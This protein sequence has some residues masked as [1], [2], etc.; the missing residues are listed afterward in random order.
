MDNSNNQYDIIRR[1]RREGDATLHLVRD[2]AADTFRVLKRYEPDIPEYAEPAYTNGLNRFMTE[3][4]KYIAAQPAG[5]AIVPAEFRRDGKTVV[6]ASAPFTGTP[7]RAYW[8]SADTAG[9]SPADKLRMVLPILQTVAA[10]NKTGMQFQAIDTDSVYVAQ[11]AVVLAEFG[12]METFEPWRQAY[13]LGRLLHSLGFDAATLPPAL[14]G[15]L[16]RALFT[17]PATRYPDAESFARDVAAFYTV[18]QTPLP[19]STPYAQP[20]PFA[21]PRSQNKGCLTAAIAVIAVLVVLSVVTFFAMRAGV[22]NNSS[23]TAYSPIPTITWDIMDNIDESIFDNPIFSSAWP[24]ATGEPADSD[25]DD[26]DYSDEDYED[27]RGVMDTAYVWYD[28]WDSY[29][30]YDGLAVAYDGTT[31]YRVRD[32]GDVVLTSENRAGTQTDLL[33]NYIPAF[34]CADKD[35]LY[36]VD[37]LD[38]YTL[39]RMERG[40]GE[41]ECIYASPCAFLTLDAAGNCIYFSD[42][43]R[44]GRLTRLSLDTLETETM[45][46][47]EANC[48]TLDAANRMLYYLDADDDDLIY[49]YNILTDTAEPLGL[50]GFDLQVHDGFLYYMG[51][52]GFLYRYNTASGKSER[53]VRDGVYAYVAH[54][55][56]VY[57]VDERKGYN[58]YRQTIGGGSA[59]FLAED[60]DMLWIADGKL[61][62]TSYDDY[63]AMK[64]CDLSGGNIEMLDRE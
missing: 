54:G 59:I 47:A 18:G 27:Y 62:Y 20:S 49:R 42:V 63:G 44:S 3:C 60:V 21:A 30:L 37:C 46:S 15:A 35:Y 41:P 4:E 32:K 10:A 50:Y 16:R 45:D 48:L 25:Y 7:W 29:S 56:S 11:Y 57:Y 64:R 39:Y 13:M 22:S 28:F 1:I 58:V 12:S 51:S 5:C 19:N 61:Y 53:I 38:N 14:A 52:T 24:S 9:T 34:L 2:G 55:D 36:F 31:Y 43:T 33:W 6:L 23:N 40:G 17:D 26:Y 8:Q